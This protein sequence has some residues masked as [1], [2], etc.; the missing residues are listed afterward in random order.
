M[1]VADASIALAWVLPDEQSAR[2]DALMDQRGTGG[3]CVPA[4]FAL[5]VTNALLGAARRGRLDPADLDGLIPDLRAMVE[6]TD[7]I[8]DQAA[9][10]ASLELARQY[11]LS[12]YDAAYLELAL[13]R[14]LPLATLDDKLAAAARHAGVDVLPE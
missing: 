13:R 1:F 7:S 2:V 11:Q 12:S 8:T 10:D 14:Q 9:W 3:V 5:E 6:E 4:H